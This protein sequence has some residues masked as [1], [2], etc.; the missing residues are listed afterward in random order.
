MCRA[1][2]QNGV[3]LQYASDELKMNRE[4]VLEAVRQ[5]GMSIHCVPWMNS[6]LDV[7]F[8]AVSQNGFALSAFEPFQ[9]DTEV[10]MQAVSQNGLSLK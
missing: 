5:N 4:L 2:A 9:D 3:S 8:Y 10:V 7:A 6:D 1:V